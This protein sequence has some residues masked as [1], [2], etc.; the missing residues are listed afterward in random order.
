MRTLKIQRTIITLCLSL[1]MNLSCAQ[2]SNKTIID[3]PDNSMGE[4]AKT[5]FEAVSSNNISLL[6]PYGIIKDGWEG[7]FQMMVS[8]IKDKGG[9][10]PFSISYFTDDFISVYSRQKNG[11]WIT[12]QLGLNE[13][14]EIL[15]MGMR[16]ASKPEDHDLKKGMTVDQVHQV[17]AAIAVEFETNYVLKEKRTVLK[18]FLLDKMKA[19]TFD[20]IDQSDMLAGVLTQ[21]LVKFA[22]DKHLQVIP[23]SQLSEV[24]SRFGLVNSE[25]ISIEEVDDKGH[26]RSP[27]E[28][29]ELEESFPISGK[30]LEGNIGYIRMERFVDS[31]KVVAETERIMNV[32]SETSAVIVDLTKSGGGDSAAHDNL[33]SYFFTTALSV[34]ENSASQKLTP[35]R[36]SSTYANKPLYVLTSRTSISAAESFAYFLQRQD[37]AILIGETTAGAG[38]RVDAYALPFEF[39]LVNSIGS[40]YDPGKNRGWQGTGVKP[41]IKTSAQDAL[42]EALSL[43]K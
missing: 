38:F 13:K 29:L 35:K 14:K 4:F 16:K 2:N 22:D 12:V 8:L 28:G 3:Y 32:L 30:I 15:A 17:I 27:G 18:N 23:P 6:K 33:M 7:H 31:P 21:L 41:D 26:H 11:G 39:Y 25:E 19:G 20:E 37:R 43:I 5:W 42:Q 34:N 9:L 36:L 10:A 24:K 40:G 1:L